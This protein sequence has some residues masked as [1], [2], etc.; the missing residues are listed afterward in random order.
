MYVDFHKGALD[1][2]I[3][4]LY[5]VGETEF[6][7]QGSIRSVRFLLPNTLETPSGPLIPA[8]TW[9]EARR[10]HAASVTFYPDGNL[11]S[12]RLEKQSQIS[13]P[14]NIGLNRQWVNGEGANGQCANDQGANDQVANCQ[15]ANGQGANGQG[16]NAQDAN[17]RCS[18]DQGANDQVANCQHVNNQNVNDQV[19]N[20]QNAKNLNSIKSGEFRLNVERIAWYPNGAIRALFPLDGRISAYWTLKDE[21]ALNQPCQITLF[22]GSFVSNFLL[23]AVF[24]YPSGSL[25]SLSLWPGET[26]TIPTPIGPIKARLSL[27][28]YPDGR[29]KTLEPAKEIVVPTP[30]GE[31]SAFDPMALGF[32]EGSLGFDLDGKINKLTTLS[33]IRWENAGHSGQTEVFRPMGRLNP[34]SEYSTQYFPINLEFSAHTVQIR[35][36]L[37][38]D[39]G[40]SW[41]L[42]GGQ[43]S[44]KPM[45]IIR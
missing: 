20:N 34:L 5:G 25:K 15:W 37:P 9:G 27:S 42:P 33:V 39:P 18:N 19:A 7:P 13:G 17:N 3:G 14:K 21:R 31:I 16:A 23:S 44:V 45:R 40:S 35:S 29:L 22:D 1:S 32:F 12:L 10:K 28:F 38:D 36:S 6:Y 24:F 2:P 43:V 4:S 11:K 8:Y 41:P 26:A 30:W